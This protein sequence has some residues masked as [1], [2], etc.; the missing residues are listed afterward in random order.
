MLI[1]E[2]VAVVI[3]VGMV[4]AVLLLRR[5]HDD[6]HSV[7][8]YHR[9]LHTLEEIRTHPTGDGQNGH[10]P[11]E[12]PGQRSPRLGLLDGPADRARADHPPARP[13]PPVANTSEPVTFDDGNPEPVP[14]TFMT[15]NEDRVIHSI[16]HRPRRLGGPAAAVAAVA[17]LV[18]VLVVTGLHSNTGPHHGKAVT[19]ATT[20]PT[21]H[22]HHAGTA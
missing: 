6:V 7:E 14:A 3:V 4:T 10:D 17:V 9:Q 8:H 13:P 11:V 18:V 2:I 12:F 22:R 5:S 21:Q 20:T 1:A 19:P 15:G 16:N